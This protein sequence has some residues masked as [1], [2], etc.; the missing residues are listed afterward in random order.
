[1]LYCYCVWITD[2]ERL[3]SESARFRGTKRFLLAISN[4]MCGYLPAW[5][6]GPRVLFE[7][8]PSPFFSYLRAV[9]PRPGIKSRHV[10]S[11]WDVPMFK[12]LNVMIVSTENNSLSPVLTKTETWWGVVPA[13]IELNKKKPVAFGEGNTAHSCELR[14]WDSEVLQLA[15]LFLLQKICKF[16]FSMAAE[17]KGSINFLEQQIQLWNHVTQA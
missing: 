4:K 7:F 3:K 15:F 12:I 8:L 13:P 1:M 17:T 6:T 11:R 5:T 10:L 16:K 14:G 2:N 9:S